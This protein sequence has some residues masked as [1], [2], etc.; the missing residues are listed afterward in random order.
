MR[1]IRG[2][3]LKKHKIINKE[4]INMGVYQ[5]MINFAV[6]INQYLSKKLRL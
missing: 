1:K 2:S 5:K 6:K 3:C 4:Q